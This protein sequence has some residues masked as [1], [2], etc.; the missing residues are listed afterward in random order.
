MAKKKS[1]RRPVRKSR[2][3]AGALPA[4]HLLL[5][6]AFATLVRLL[7]WPSGGGSGLF[8]MLSAA[9]VA[10]SLLF[11]LL[12]RWLMR[13]P[14]PAYLSAL[15]LLSVTAVWMPDLTLWRPWAALVP[16]SFALGALLCHWDTKLRKGKR[17]DFQLLSFA[18]VDGIVALGIIALSLLV[19]LRPVRL[20]MLPILSGLLIGAAGICAVLLAV[21]AFSR[22][23]P[24]D[25]V[26]GMVLY[27]VV[28]K[29][30]GFP[31]FES[32]L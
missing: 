25:L 16:L 17:A 6:A 18:A 5:V 11:Y 9:F 20:G 22:R 13:D 29:L 19:C 8:W 27:A 21:S 4:R 12:V 3:S 2:R 1:K 30:L 26:L 32:F 7:P 23:Q 14:Y 24:W 28:W 31:G 15:V 10:G